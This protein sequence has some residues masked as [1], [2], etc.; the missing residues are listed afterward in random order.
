MIDA[1]IEVNEEFLQG[2]YN[3]LLGTIDCPDYDRF[4][5]PVTSECHNSC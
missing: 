5:E 2:L 1:Q 4:C 3:I